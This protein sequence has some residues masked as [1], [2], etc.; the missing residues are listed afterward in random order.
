[1]CQNSNQNIY[2][3]NNIKAIETESFNIS[4]TVHPANSIILKHSHKKPYLCLLVSGKYNEKSYYS[5]V[6]KNGN[7]LYR[8]INYEHSNRFS[9]E[10]GICLNLEINYPEQFIDQNN[11]ILPELRLEQKASINIYKL[12]Y[13]FKSNVSKDI[14]NIYCYE[15]FLSHF[16]NLK[17]KGK[18]IWVKKVK[19][20]IND[21]KLNTISLKTLSEE[22]QLHPNYI[23]R[24]F[25]E[26]T[27][28]TLSEYLIKI[29]LEYSIK[30]LIQTK[31]KLTDIAL[32]SGFYDQSH[33]NKNFTKNIKTTPS[34]FRKIIKS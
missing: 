12:L 15:S 32:N 27:G 16:E 22:F 19:E 25:K 24:K 1:M 26:V 8:P 14:L 9:N 34:L 3:G 20:Y 4:L 7:V 13:S 23:V 17:V 28:Y 2:H 33:F 10:Q 29:R 18:L 11:F 21:N 5:F 6:T 30:N 31:S